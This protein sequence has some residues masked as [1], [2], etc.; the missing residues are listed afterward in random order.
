MEKTL[1]Y[2]H[3]AGPNGSC[4]LV[5]IVLHG[6]IFICLIQSS[7][8]EIFT[9]LVDIT[10][11][12]VFK[13]PTLCSSLCSNCKYMAGWTSFTVCGKMRRLV[14]VKKVIIIVIF[15]TLHL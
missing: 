5:F 1:P 3:T 13:Y 12:E 6:L 11:H 7:S 2:A 9:Y 8:I 10:G 4:Y 15:T 14:K